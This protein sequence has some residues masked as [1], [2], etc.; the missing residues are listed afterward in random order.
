VKAT[1]LLAKQTQI[2]GGRIAGLQ[3]MSEAQWMARPGQGRNRVGFTAWH[4]VATRDWTIRSIL[5]AERPVGWDV[6]F[7]GSGIA[8]C[9]LPFGMSLEEADQIAEAVTPADVAA[10]SDA[11][12]S[13]ILRWLERTDEGAL[14]APPPNGRAHLVFSSRY[15]EAG[16]REELDANSSGMSMTDWPTWQLLTRPAFAHCLFHLEEMEFAK[17][18]A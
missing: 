11:V 10:Y 7:A 18:N 14:D 8:K 9:D 15:D 16:Y 4:M 6:P 12:T 13:E 2:V 5:Q 17:T 1:E 3:G